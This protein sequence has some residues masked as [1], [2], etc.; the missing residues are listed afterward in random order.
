M[1]Q[2]RFVRQHMLLLHNTASLASHQAEAKSSRE[3]SSLLQLMTKC[4]KHMHHLD[5]V[6]AVAMMMLQL[7]HHA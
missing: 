6:I 1:P 3:A 2:N 5:E 4:S 7:L